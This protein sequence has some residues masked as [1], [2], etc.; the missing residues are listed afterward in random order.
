MYFPLHPVLP[1]LEK[2][3]TDHYNPG[4]SQR[5]ALFASGS[6][7]GNGVCSSNPNAG[8][9]R[10]SQVD[11]LS[12]DLET[13]QLKNLLDTN[14]SNLTSTQAE[15]P[16]APHTVNGTE[17]ESLLKSLGVSTFN[18]D[19]QECQDTMVS[20]RESVTVEM[21]LAD[22]PY[23]LPTS[24]VP[25]GVGY[26]DHIDEKE[27]E[28]FCQ[29]VR[30]VLIPGGY[31]ILFTSF[32]LFAKWKTN[33]KEQDFIVLGYP[34]TIIKETALLQRSSSVMLPQNGSEF[35]IIARRAG[36]HPE[37]FVPRINTPYR[38]IKCSHSRKFAVVDNVPPI[39]RKLKYPRSNRPV[40]IEEKNTLLL[41][42]LLNTFCPAG[43]T[44][45]D[46]YA[47]TLSTAI[48]C[49]ATGRK[50]IATEKDKICFDIALD[51]LEM[52]AGLRKGMEVNSKWSQSANN[53]A[54]A[55]S[56]MKVLLEVSKYNGNAD[57]CDD[58]EERQDT[59][60]ISDTES[61][62]KDVATIDGM[63]NEQTPTDNR[64][65]DEDIE[66]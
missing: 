57:D 23:S 49:I 25:T 52:I 53:A 3:Y 28:L 13:S 50:C 54:D 26:E 31:C 60:T 9:N 17:E 56:V 29:F 18:M 11:P 5:I 47:G 37:G 65:G 12:N 48:A 33:F 2:V 64:P 10:D 62:T 14:N 58:G 66:E 32:H 27:M 8:K 7:N 42:E 39:R 51:R 4:A 22:P 35:A 43:G 38:L 6:I 24:R 36:S 40:R 15:D 20:S 16:I 21:V 34:M 1:R 44:V 30:R 41:S 61:G 59:N 19:W 55:S 63:M 46:A 45:L